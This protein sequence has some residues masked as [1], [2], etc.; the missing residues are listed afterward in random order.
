MSGRRGGAPR[1]AAIALSLGLLIFAFPGEA[2]AQR[3]ASRRA[4]S[5]SAARPPYS[6]GVRLSRGVV[7]LG[8]PVVYRGF[9]TGGDPGRVRFFT[10][11]SGGAFTWGRLRAV[12]RAPRGRVAPGDA[13]GGVKFADFDTVFVET[14]L[15]AFAAGDLAVPGLAFEIDD[16]SGPRSGRLPVTKLVVVPMVTAADT[17]ADLRSLRG[18]LAAPW[19]ERVPWTRVAQALVLLAALAAAIVWWRRRRLPIEVASPAT[20]R[21]PASQALAELEALR[22]VNLPARGRFAEHAFRLGRIVRRFLE[23][24]TGTPLPGDTTPEFVT[25]LE[26][27][28]LDEV[29]VRRI[30]ELMRFWDRVKF[31]RAEESLEEASRAEHSVESLVRRLGER[32]APGDSAAAPGEGR[33]A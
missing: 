26:A 4:L 20:A 12:V 1:G 27:A 25:H 23:A 21:D 15:Q 19:W 5:P 7:K 2:R 14:S 28:Q 13:G 17:A 22:R 9:I 11:D 18:P 3:A 32:K 31:A 8:Q 29:D 33:A 10:P 16:G 24:T 6:I 30:D